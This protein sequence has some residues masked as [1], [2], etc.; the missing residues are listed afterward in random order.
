M[1][2]KLHL[3]DAHC[4]LQDQ[5]VARLAP[6]LIET[7]GNAGVRLFAVNG[8]SEEDW[9]LVRQMGEAHSSVIPCFGLHPWFVGKRSPNWLTVLRGFF[10]TVPCAAVGEIGLDKG[11][12]QGK[13]VD[14]SSQ[15]QVFKQQLELARQLQR[16]ATIHCVSAFGDLQEIVQEMGTFPA[17]II[18]HSYLGSAETVKSLV[19][20]G[21]YF[22]FSGFL[23]SMKPEKAKKMLQAVPTDR[24]LLETDAPD[25]LPRVNP[26]SL[27]WV[28]GDPSVP[29][30]LK[31]HSEGKV[32]SS[33]GILAKEESHIQEGGTN[34]RDYLSLPKN[35][36]NHPANIYSVLKYVASLLEIS[37][38]QLAQISYANAMR[39]FTYSGSKLC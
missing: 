3:F 12:S 33:V 4:H 25:A 2:T 36:L 18:L 29:Q 39:V 26:G 21:A 9:E 6:Q 7:A 28:P 35:T 31:E 30:E 5:R 34:K 19:K 13:A 27:V 8:T 22:S 24:I 16:P 10:D 17:G 37:E 14:F 1:A 11:C 15:T 23:T 20:F 38:E 32:I